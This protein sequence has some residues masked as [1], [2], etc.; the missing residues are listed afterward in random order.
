MNDIRDS[1]NQGYEDSPVTSS[2]FPMYKKQFEKIRYKIVQFITKWVDD[3]QFPMDE[4]FNT[5]WLE[6][7]GLYEMKD[8]DFVKVLNSLV[9]DF[10]KSL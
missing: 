7:V 8:Q 5:S 2:Y 9:D 10:L 1:I 6:H 4:N 3:F